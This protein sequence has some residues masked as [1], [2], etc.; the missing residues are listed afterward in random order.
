LVAIFI[1]A[2]GLLALLTL[3]PLGA[4]R[5]LK[6]IQDERCAQAGNNASTIGVM[7]SIGQLQ[8]LVP[9]LPAGAAGTYDP[10]LNPFAPGQPGSPPNTQGEFPSYP[11]LVDPVGA[12]AF[13]ST[14]G[15]QLGGTGQ[16][17][18][19][20]FS[21]NFAQ[22]T[23][24]A[25]QWFTLQDDIDFE[26]AQPGTGNSPAGTP[27]LILP[28]PPAPVPGTI[29]RDTRYSY[30]YLLQRPRYADASVIDAVVVVYNKRTV[31]LTAQLSPPEYVYNN[32]A[33][34]NLATNSITIDYTNNV[35]PPTRVGDW[36]LDATPVP[37][38][39]NSATAHGYFYRVV[40]ITDLGN[41]QLEFEVEQP[42]RGFPTPLNA[43]ANP[44]L[45]RGTIIV[46]DGVAEVYTRGPSR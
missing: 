27:R 5:M 42:I 30:A 2:I 14:N 43:P 15:L 39:G 24:D 3:F 1:M 31:T 8:T 21:V 40:G 32:A 18:I 25:L 44:P 20:R 9:P 4:L 38:P 28:V 7:G 41:N 26:N 37:L 12:S 22:R 23:Q 17:A 16:S 35:P 29:S 6:A 34:F 11:V 13:G 36:L 19:A 46:L 10:Y 45:Y 33:A